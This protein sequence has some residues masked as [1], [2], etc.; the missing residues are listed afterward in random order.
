M[1][2]ILLVNKSTRKLQV[3]VKGTDPIW[4]QFFPVIIAGSEDGKDSDSREA[5][6][7][8]RLEKSRNIFSPTT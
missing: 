4:S 8:Q 2:S 1:D 5:G 6:R 3:Q 7:L